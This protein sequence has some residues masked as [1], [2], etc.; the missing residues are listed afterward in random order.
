MKYG[1]SIQVGEPQKFSPTYK[2]V[3]IFTPRSS[4]AYLNP[5]AN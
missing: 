1:E 3:H 4:P 5:Q 2:S